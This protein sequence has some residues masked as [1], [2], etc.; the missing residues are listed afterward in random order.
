M[1]KKIILIISISF[2]LLATIGFTYAFF[3]VTV[4]GE[5]SDEIVET[6]T[7][8]L[9]YTDGQEIS[10][11]QAL[12]GQSI[13][14]KITITNTGTLSTS[15]SI[16][17][18]NLINTIINN[19]L[20]LEATC[21]SYS[22]YDNKIIEGTCKD[23]EKTPIIESSISTSSIIKEEILI[24][25]GITHEYEIKITFIEKND[26]QNYNQGKTFSA[27]INIDKHINW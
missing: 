14:K 27:I 12:P 17:F 16:S 4:T 3:T 21:T 10:L 11:N 1:N 22:D 20:V 13:T 23:I 8:S 2:L 9:H 5:V 24:D 15:Y 19:E 25:S 18:L 6:G 26:S 7:L